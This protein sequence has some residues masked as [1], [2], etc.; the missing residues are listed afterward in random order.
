PEQPIQPVVPEYRAHGRW[1]ALARHLVLRDADRSPSLSVNC[2]V[3]DLLFAP[4]AE[5]F[6]L[7]DLRRALF[8]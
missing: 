3:G 2:K 8:G 5:M 1:L 6:P 7:I 4:P